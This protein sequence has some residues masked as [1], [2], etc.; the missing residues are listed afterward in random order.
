MGAPSVR[1]ADM[2]VIR[3]EGGRTG[4][5]Y[6]SNVRIFAVVSVIYGLKS[7]P[8]ALAAR[9]HRNLYRGIHGNYFVFNR[10]TVY[11]PD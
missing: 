1:V 8:E 4:P 7:Y 3:P 9:R 11:D 10:N 5:P 2:F 6:R